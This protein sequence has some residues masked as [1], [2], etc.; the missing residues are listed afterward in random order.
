MMGRRMED[1]EK[2]GWR[3]GRMRRRREDLPLSVHTPLPLSPPFRLPP[4]P[5]PPPPPPYFLP[6]LLP[7]PPPPPPQLLP[8]PPPHSNLANQVLI[9]QYVPGCQISV[10]KPFPGKVLHSTGHF[11]AE[12]EE[13]LR[14]VRT[15]GQ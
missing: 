5:Y 12:G 13:S 11:L 1:R 3:G 15:N 4:P 7:L 8:S 2:G 6:P 9:E 10:D 14:E